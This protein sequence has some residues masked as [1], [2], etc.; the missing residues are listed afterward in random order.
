MKQEMAMYLCEAG[1]GMY[2]CEA[3]NGDVSFVKQEMVMTFRGLN[4]FASRCMYS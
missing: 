1:N 3:G 4:T 2:L